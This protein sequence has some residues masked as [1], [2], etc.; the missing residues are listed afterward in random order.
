MAKEKDLKQKRQE[1]H[2]IYHGVAER[3]FKR[4][5][6]LIAALTILIV[7]LMI[8]VATFHG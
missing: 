8:C 2:V 1:V 7:A 3:R 5:M 4:K 6:M